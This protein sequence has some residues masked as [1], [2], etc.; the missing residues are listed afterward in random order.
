[1]SQAARGT[2]AAVGGA[3][4]ADAAARAGLALLLAEPTPPAR[5]LLAALELYPHVDV[6]ARVR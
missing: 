2:G 1:M 4:G 6:I 5:R 3:A